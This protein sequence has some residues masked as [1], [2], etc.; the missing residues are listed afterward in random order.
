M[1]VENK[2]I[3]V[4]QAYNKFVTSSWNTERSEVVL[5]YVDDICYGE[6]NVECHKMPQ[7]SSI[8]LY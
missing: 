5:K 7:C 8:S 1:N 3:E 4:S 2:L 6:G